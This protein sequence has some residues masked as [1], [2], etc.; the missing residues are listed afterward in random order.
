M[1]MNVERTLTCVGRTRGV[2]ALGRHPVKGGGS[3]TVKISHK[4]VRKKHP[5]TLLGKCVMTTT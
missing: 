5:E 1:N 2:I 4:W 3:F